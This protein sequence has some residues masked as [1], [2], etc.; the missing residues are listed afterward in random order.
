MEHEEWKAKLSEPQEPPRQEET[1]ITNYFRVVW[2]VRSY[3]HAIAFPPVSVPGAVKLPSPTEHT[4]AFYEAPDGG[5]WRMA[6]IK[7]GGL[8]LRRV[9]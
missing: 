8:T 9:A 5:C 6:T 1:E 2:V 7:T 4:V 3:M